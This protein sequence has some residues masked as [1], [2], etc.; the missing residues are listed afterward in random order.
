MF[1]VDVGM[2]S[3]VTVGIVTIVGIVGIVAPVVIA[4]PVGTV[5]LARMPEAATTSVA[6]SET[7]KT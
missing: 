7:L 4:A 1:K 5:D 2:R 6:Q 3:G